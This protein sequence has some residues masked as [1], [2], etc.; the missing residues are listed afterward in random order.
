MARLRQDRLESEE[1]RFAGVGTCPA[2]TNNPIEVL[3]EGGKNAGG[4]LGQVLAAGNQGHRFRCLK[5]DQ[6][7]QTSVGWVLHDDFDEIG[8]P[9]R[10]PNAKVNSRIDLGR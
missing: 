7:Q 3:R 2:L 5:F 9:S 4:V 8:Y 1:L 10:G 6:G